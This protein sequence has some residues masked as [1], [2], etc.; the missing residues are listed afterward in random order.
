MSHKINGEIEVNGKKIRVQVHSEVNCDDMTMVTNNY[1]LL[2]IPEGKLYGSDTLKV[3]EYTVT[4][5][6]CTIT[7]GESINGS[8]KIEMTIT[9]K[10]ISE[11]KSNWFLSLFGY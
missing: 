9:P 5:N 10:K 4:D 8:S 2:L 7:L 6:K 11:Q 1:H 3:E